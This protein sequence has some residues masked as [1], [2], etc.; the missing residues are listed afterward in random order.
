MDIESGCTCISVGRAHFAVCMLH[1]KKRFIGSNLFS[2]W[3]DKSEEE[4]KKSAE[5]L[6]TFTSIDS[7]PAQPPEDLSPPEVKPQKAVIARRLRNIGEDIQKLTDLLSRDVPLR[8]VYVRERRLL[9]FSKLHVAVNSLADQLN[10]AVLE[11]DFNT[12]GDPEF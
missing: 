2:A 9:A 4:W 5:L 12:E 10:R 6:E 7:E 8:S 11:F 1:K 3:K